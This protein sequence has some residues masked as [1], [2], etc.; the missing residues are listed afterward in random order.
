MVA[1]QTLLQQM[2][3]RGGLVKAFKA[4]R[5]L[6]SYGIACRE[7]GKSKITQE[8]YSAQW[9]QSR[10][11]TTREIRAFV[12]CVPEGVTVDQLWAQVE[13]FVRERDQAAAV[14]QVASVRVAL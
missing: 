13:R 12:A 6:V 11:T 7:L 5:Y 9:R 14:A 1:E 3:A 8:V 2:V 10:A 4:L